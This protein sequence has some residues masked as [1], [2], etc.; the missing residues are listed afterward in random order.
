[1]KKTTSAAPAVDKVFRAFSDR[2]R[3][4]ILHL[5]NSVGECCVGDI[6][7]V[8]RIE[9]P[10]ASRHLAYLRQARLVSVR[11]AKNWIYY[12]L[13]ASSSPFHTKL[14]E[15]LGCCFAE[16]PQLRADAKRAAGLKK[17]GSGC[18]PEATPESSAG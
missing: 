16:V 12:S 18:C 2:T 15:C 17:A 6:V 11:R 14:L 5:L 13:A 1:M 10:A 3:L 8:L 4:R 9:Q 7:H